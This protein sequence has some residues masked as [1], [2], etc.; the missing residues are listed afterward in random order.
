MNQIFKMAFRDL[1]RNRRRSLLSALAVAAGMALLLLMASVVEGEMRGAM[2][3]TIR[4]Q[5][6]HVQIRAASYEEQQVSLDWQDLITDP[7]ALIEQLKALPQV[8]LAT[9][10]LFASGIVARGDESRGVQVIGIDPAS[11]A[12]LPFRQG[13]LA[14]EFLAPDDREGALIG[15]PLAEKL[16]MTVGDQINLLVNLSDGGV[17]QQ[18][19]TIRGVYTTNTSSFDENTVF[20][21]LAKAQAFTGAQDHASSI[22]IMLQD[23][24]QAEAVAA[25]LQSPDYQV[26]TWRTMNEL[27]SQLEDFAG[28]YMVLLYVIVLGITATVVTNTLVMAVFERTR[29]IGILAAIGM[30]A[31]RIM[32]QF[33]AE[34]V[35]LA[36]GGVIGGLIL[37]GLVVAYFSRFG[38]Y[39]GNYGIQGMLLG[40]RIYAYLTVENA[41][42][43]SIVAYVIT[44]TASLYPAAMAARMEPVEAL[45]AQ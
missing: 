40:D 26:L 34:A 13:L 23:R 25:A 10:R 22:F 19:F 17:D 8:Q 2:Q 30:K 45:H 18:L 39:I 4:L 44:L 5:S 9:P 12:N 11:A 42:M 6:G 24:E 3:T 15:K 38:F 27:I 36:T 35:L 7:E 31:G 43:L 41:V 37:G 1:G 14:G 20:L 16:G 33:L 28:A 32:A 29:E 21:P